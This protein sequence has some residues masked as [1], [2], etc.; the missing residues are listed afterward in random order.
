[1][2]DTLKLG[3]I[4]LSGELVHIDFQE[5]A[6]SSEKLI[7]LLRRITEA[8]ITIPHLHQVQS[9]GT[10][11]TSL[12]IAAEDFPRL[13]VEAKEELQTGERRVIPSM[14]TIT[15]FPHRFAL[16]L[17]TRVI[18]ALIEAEIPFHGVSTS[19]SALVIHCEY[20][21]LDQAVEAILTC[22]ELPDNHTPL[23][24]V[25]LLGDQPVET[26]AVYWEPK[27]RIYGMDVQQKLTRISWQMPAELYGNEEYR[28]LGSQEEKFRLL[29][30]QTQENSVFHGELLIEDRWRKSTLRTIHAI[31]ACDSRCLG[32]FNEEEVD[33]V[34][35]HGP[36]F[37]DRYGIAERVFVALQKGGINL[38]SS[39][40]TGTSVH[41]VVGKGDGSKTAECLAEVCTVPS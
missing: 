33:L 38:L 4:K 25:V 12:C 1:M 29:L 7:T 24:P 15:L 28:K 19:I 36:H 14:G 23:R 31:L 20:L 16:G 10:I 37:Q 27:I 11:Y 3:G 34:S 8:K 40:C 6:K 30:G 17:Y 41:L 39:G 9:A 21:L 18:Q 2:V 35:F 13:A 32:S 5:S 22:C 26:I